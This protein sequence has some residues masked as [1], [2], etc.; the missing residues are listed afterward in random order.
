MATA[1]NYRHNHEDYRCCANNPEA[2]M[3][4]QS[5]LL[6]IIWSLQGLFICAALRNI[7]KQEQFFG[8]DVASIVLSFLLMASQGLATILVGFW[9]SRCSRILSISV[10]IILLVIQS[11]IAAFASQFSKGHLKN[12]SLPIAVINIAIIIIWSR[13]YL[14]LSGIV[15]DY[16]NE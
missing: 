14:G 5:C 9:R 4:C 16:E 10:S 3:R 7:G 6:V 12:T 2:A 13:Y 11:L 15:D 8:L 1:Q